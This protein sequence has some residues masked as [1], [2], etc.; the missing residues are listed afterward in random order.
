[1]KQKYKTGKTAKFRQNII[2]SFIYTFINMWNGLA[3]AHVIEPS[4]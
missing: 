2:Y 1:M 3:E 4:S